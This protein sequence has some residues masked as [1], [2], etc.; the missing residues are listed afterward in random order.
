M[1]VDMF[2]ALEGVKSGPIKGESYDKDHKDEID[3]LSW[4]WGASQTGTMHL[5]G[6]GGGGKVNYQDLTITTYYEKSTNTLLKLC[7]TGEHI[8][9]G[10]LTVRKA[11]GEAEEYIKFEIKDALVSSIST[12]GSGGEERLTV[13]ISVNFRQFEVQYFPQKEDGTLDTAV[14]YGM[15][16][17]RNQ[18]T[19]G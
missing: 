2:L 18:T 11:G 6:G 13:N 12:G 1:T 10:L 5:G 14:R 15:D 8:K 16:I 4:S 3:V 19:S 7:A 9:K 17:A